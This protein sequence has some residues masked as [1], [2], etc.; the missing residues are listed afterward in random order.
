MGTTSIEWTATQN[1][2]GTWAPGYTF[3]GWIGCEK[4]SAAC[5][6]C[7]AETDTY[8][9]VSKA[10]GL[11]LWGADAARHVT[12][13]ANWRK[14]LGWNRKAAASGQR[15]KVFAHSLSDVF[16]DRDDLRGA[17]ERLFG[18][19]VATP[20]LDWLLLT[21]RPHLVRHMV[22]ADWMANG[23]PRNVWMGTTVEDQDCAEKRVEHAL[24][25]PCSVR[26]LSCEPLV[27]DVDLTNIEPY[28]LKPE[29]NGTPRSKYDPVI[30]LDGLRGHMKGPD[31]MLDRRID[32]VIVGGESGPRA[33]PFDLDAARRIV[34][35]CKSAGVAVFVKQMG[36][37]WAR[38]TGTHRLDA[39]GGTPE[40]WPEDLRVREMPVLRGEP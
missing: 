21:K 23:F 19:I 6:N 15:A 2:D 18:L 25:W 28:Y 22:P 32:W 26:F 31:D 30:R 33:R 9:R 29:H 13:D 27:G 40:L 36:E 14:P 38:E 5:K 1:P 7:Y 8:P 4:V 39:H 35:D 37:R 16:E 34:A 24:D 11:P 3:N 20:N 12:A 10:R 17:R